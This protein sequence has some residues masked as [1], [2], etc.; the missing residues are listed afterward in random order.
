[1]PQQTAQGYVEYSKK[2]GAGKIYII[3]MFLIFTSLFCSSLFLYD[4]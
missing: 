3:K 1:M 4:I 2:A